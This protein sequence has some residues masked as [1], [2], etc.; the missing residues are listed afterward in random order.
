MEVF[1]AALVT[2]L[3]LSTILLYKKH[4]DAQS[5]LAETEDRLDSANKQI[6]RLN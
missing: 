2:A 5:R 4:A 3:V 6:D 1:I